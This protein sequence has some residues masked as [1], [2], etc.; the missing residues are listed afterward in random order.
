VVQNPLYWWHKP[1]PI[2]SSES[3]DALSK[4]KDNLM[5]LFLFDSAGQL[6][7]CLDIQVGPSTVAE[8]GPKI[9]EQRLLFPGPWRKPSRII[10]L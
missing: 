4:M 6:L 5:R 3:A 8:G 2:D 7:T 10:V 1:L 9:Y